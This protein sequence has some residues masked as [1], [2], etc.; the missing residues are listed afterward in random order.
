M[1]TNLP[2]KPD[3]AQRVRAANLRTALV[4]ASIALVF[5]LGIIATKWIG[6]PTVG[7]GVMG[8]AILVFLVFTIG[9]SLRR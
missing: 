5:F 2:T 7:I 1:D 8:A 3:D 6:G 4:F 9:R